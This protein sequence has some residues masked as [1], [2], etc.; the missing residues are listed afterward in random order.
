MKKVVSKKAV[1]KLGL[2]ELRAIEN[3]LGIFLKNPVNPKRCTNQQFGVYD[4]D[5]K[6]VGDIM[7]KGAFFTTKEL[8]AKIKAL[9]GK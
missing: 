1:S 7:A 5:E 2:R 4:E 8:K 6:H 9:F 3:Q